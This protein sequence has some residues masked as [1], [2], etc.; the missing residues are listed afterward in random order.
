ME[1]ILKGRIKSL[2]KDFGFIYCEINKTDYFFHQT[3]LDS[4]VKD[5]LAIGKIVTFKL[6]ANKG[7]EGSHAINVKLLNE[8]DKSIPILPVKRKNKY[9]FE[10]QTD[11][12]MGFRHIKE[13][14]EFQKSKCTSN[15]EDAEEIM[16]QIQELLDIIDDLLVGPN[17]NLENITFE[18]LNVSEDHEKELKRDNKNYWKDSFNL[19][20]FAEDVE[21][22][23]EREVDKGWQNDFSII[24]HEWKDKERQ[25]FHSGYF[26]GHFNYS[27]IEKGAKSAKNQYIRNGGIDPTCG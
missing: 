7:R 12:I 1:I 4:I 13:K 6:R 17:P 3:S 5:D 27:F 14:L 11:M 2:V 25:I 24:W 15:Y 21:T 8:I 16:C 19:Q 23:S 22:I 10:S 9:F 26:K 18:D 20:K